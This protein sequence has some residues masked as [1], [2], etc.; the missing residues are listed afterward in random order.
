[1]LLTLR[2]KKNTAATLVFPLADADGQ[3]ITG[4]AALDSEKSQDG[5]GFADCTNETAEIGTTGWYALTLTAAELNYGTIA[6]R[7]QTS[8]AGIMPMAFMVATYEE[9]LE[10]ANTELT[11]VPTTTSSTRLQ[12]Q[13]VFEYFRNVRTETASV[14]S[15]KK[16]D[17]LTE[18][19][20]RTLTDDGTTFTRSEMNT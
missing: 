11:S 8:T 18:L 2:L 5:G 4:A 6:V 7:I 20:S 14:E 13:F 19:G 10:I 12:N 15:L 9:Q 1:M 17:G 16:E 3:P